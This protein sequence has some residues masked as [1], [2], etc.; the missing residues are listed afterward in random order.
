MYTH[1]SFNPNLRKPKKIRDLQFRYFHPS[2]RWQIRCQMAWYIIR[3]APLQWRYKS[4]VVSQ[5]TGNSINCFKFVQVATKE[6]PRL[7][8]NGPYKWNPP[9]TDGLTSQRAVRESKTGKAIFIDDVPSEA[10]KAGSDYLKRPVR[11][12]FYIMYRKSIFPDLWCDGIIETFMSNSN[13]WCINQYVFF[14]Q[15]IALKI[16]GS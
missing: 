10:L 3:Y 11:H 13:K 9:V 7:H 12:L 1:N 16:I 8:I 2:N 14:N 15:T 6:T 5:I 4:V